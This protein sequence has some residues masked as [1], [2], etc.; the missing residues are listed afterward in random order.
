MKNAIAIWNY[1][2]NAA[3]VPAWIH[4]F[5]DHG[6]DAIS[7]NAAQFVGDGG[8]HISAAVEALRSRDMIA[9]IHGSVAMDIRAI[10]PLV[11][12]LGDRLSAVTLDSV[13]REDSRGRLHDAK[14]VATALSTLQEMTKDAVTQLAIEDFPL[15]SFALEHF[16][17]DL[18]AVYQ[19]PRTGILI[20]VGHMH[21]R[22]KTSDYFR[23]IPVLDYFRRLPFR[24][25]EVHLHDNHGA[26]DEHAH[27][28]FGDVPFQEIAA[29]LKMLRFDGVCTIEIAPSFHGSNPEQSKPHAF[30]SLA[31]W[32][33]LMK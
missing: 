1:C 5:A 7:F 26:K 33:R 8:R 15:D 10:A 4:E 16:A 31:T 13:M 21:M 17:P 32:R 9:T 12:A 14:R 24:L 6:F 28:G 30:E 11:E 20:D 2:W 25:V 3:E 29:A 19:H 27:L 18:G 23:A 22:M